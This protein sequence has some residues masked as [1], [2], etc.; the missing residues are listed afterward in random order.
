VH[1]GPHQETEE[2]ADQAGGGAEPQLEAQEVGHGLGGD[3]GG[4]GGVVLEWDV[5]IVGDKQGQD[6]VERARG[7]EGRPGLWQ[8]G[9]QDQIQGQAQQPTCHKI[10]TK[11]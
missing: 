1:R 7:E 9:R 11:F 8:C 2:R 3:D 5:E 10:R 4:G 6:Q